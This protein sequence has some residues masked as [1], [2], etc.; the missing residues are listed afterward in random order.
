V[1]KTYFCT[2]PYIYKYVNIYIYTFISAKIDNLPR[3]ACSRALSKVSKVKPSLLISSWKVV[4][5]VSLPATLKSMV[6]RASSKP[7]ISVKMTG[8]SPVYAG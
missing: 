3:L 7:N 5:P 2:F 8:S 4:I 1:L 6:P